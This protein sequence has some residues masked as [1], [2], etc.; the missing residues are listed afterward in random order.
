MAK[1]PIFVQ[2]CPVCGRRLNVR[3]EYLGKI[4][5]CSHCRGEF[6]AAD[7][8]SQRSAPGATAQSLL[9]KADLLLKRAEREQARVR[10]GHPR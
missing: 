8:S 1:S 10:S 6:V 5:A 3:V 9:Q 4:V 2:N 7:P